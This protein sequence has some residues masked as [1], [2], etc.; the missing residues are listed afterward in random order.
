MFL[1]FDS[2]LSFVFFTDIGSSTTG[3]GANVSEPHHV[4]PLLLLCRIKYYSSVTHINLHLLQNLLVFCS[5]E[6]SSSADKLLL[7]GLSEDVE[8]GDSTVA[9]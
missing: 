3:R 2:F 6:V 5:N 9:V 8:G 1:S 7:D 4:F